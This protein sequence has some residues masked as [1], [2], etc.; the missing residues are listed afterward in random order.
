MAIANTISANQASAGHRDSSRYSGAGMRGSETGSFDQHHRKARLMQHPQR[1]GTH[2]QIGQRAA[3]MRSHDDVVTLELTRHAE[4]CDRP[5]GPTSSCISYGIP[6]WSSRLRRRPQRLFA[7]LVLVTLDLRRRNE[8]ADVACAS[9]TATLSRCSVGRKPSR[10]GRN[11]VVHGA[12]RALRSI[13]R[14]KDDLHCFSLGA[15]RYEFARRLRACHCR[16][17]PP[18]RTAQLE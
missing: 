9:H 7:L 15:C 4:R 8:L 14:Y 17:M 2:Q 12:Q 3:A 1:R 16:I 10:V 6:A 18:A 11:Q 13:D 5:R